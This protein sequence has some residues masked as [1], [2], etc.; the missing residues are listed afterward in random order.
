MSKRKTFFIVCGILCGVG[1]LLALTG[2][3]LGGAVTGVGYEPG[4]GL[5]VY[6][7]LVSNQP[8][9]PSVQTDKIDQL[10]PFTRIDIRMDYADITIEES[11]HFSLE[12]E[13]T[14][15]EKPVISVKNGCLTISQPPHNYG[16]NRFFLFGS[17]FSGTVYNSWNSSREYLTVYIPE[18]TQLDTVYVSTS[19]GKTELSG[20]KT[21]QLTIDDDYGDARLTDITCTSADFS[22]SSGKFTAD[23]LKAESLKL[24]DDYGDCILK[25][26]EIS[27]NTTLFL[28]S[29]TLKMQQSST[30][31]LTVDSDYGNVDLNDITS[32][33]ARLTLSS[34]DMNA[35]G[36]L[37][38]NLDIKSDYGSV[39]LV[40]QL[41]DSFGYDLKTD[42]GDIR[43]NKHDLGDTYYT[44]DKEFD[45][46]VRIKCSSGDIRITTQK[47]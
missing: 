9:G 14:A 43:I 3:L 17:S 47:E 22:L 13:L 38:K 2:R 27:G 31:A 37:F 18:N 44:F 28:S 35:E 23:N 42:Y 41:T 40:T 4:N 30:G 36:F 16:N 7:P 11:D 32:E 33:N 21:G 39:E 15:W 19:S 20:L 5:V 25:N 10:E 12:Y 34:G 29:G 8:N 24:S 45:N 46:W 1:M 26:S 6:S